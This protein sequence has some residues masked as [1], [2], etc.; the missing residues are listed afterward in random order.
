MLATEPL[1]EEFTAF[2]ND[3]IYGLD[4]GYY[5]NSAK[6]VEKFEDAVAMFHPDLLPDHEFVMYKLLPDVAEDAAE[7]ELDKAG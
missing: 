5:M 1:F 6:V 2:K 4:K 7:K 3:K